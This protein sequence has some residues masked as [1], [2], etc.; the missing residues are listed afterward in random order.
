MLQ[1][2]A[3]EDDLGKTAVLAFYFSRVEWYTMLSKLK[4]GQIPVG[5]V[6]DN[7]E[8]KTAVFHQLKL[9][10]VGVTAVSFFIS[11]TVCDRGNQF[12]LLSFS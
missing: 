10:M 5:N 4:Q 11:I 3:E 9:G 2:C 12:L 7:S 1:S 6:N 8:G